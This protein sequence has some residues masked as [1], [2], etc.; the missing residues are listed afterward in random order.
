M[1]MLEATKA[2]QHML[3]EILTEA[4]RGVAISEQRYVGYWVPQYQSGYEENVF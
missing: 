4:T 2:S 3:Q 1:K